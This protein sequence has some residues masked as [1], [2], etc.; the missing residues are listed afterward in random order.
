M[1]NNSIYWCGKNSSSG[2]GI[3]RVHPDGSGFT[4][5][6]STGI[7]RR[8]IRGIA[9][10]WVASKYPGHRGVMV[11]NRTLSQERLSCD[12]YVIYFE[13]W[14]HV[15]GLIEGI[16]QEMKCVFSVCHHNMRLSI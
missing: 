6:V 14:V 11:I 13:P 4:D 3:Y 5:V 7:G 12:C 8:G 16:Y 1:R 2:G 10:D 9:V 15:V